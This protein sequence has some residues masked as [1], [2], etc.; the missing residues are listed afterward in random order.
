MIKM[1]TEEEMKDGMRNGMLVCAKSEEFLK[2][3]EGESVH[4]IYADPPFCTG[5]LFNGSLPID[6]IKKEFIAFEDI[7]K[8]RI[9]GYINRMKI[10]LRECHRILKPTGSMYLH[11][12]HHVLH[13]LKVAMDEIFGPKNFRNDIIWRRTNSTKSSQYD[14]KKYSVITDNILFYSKDYKNLYFSPKRT[15]LTEEEKR[16]KYNLT[17]ERGRYYLRTLLRGK[18][19]GERPNLVYEYEGFTPDIYGWRMKKEKVIKLDNEGNLVFN[20]KGKP[21]RKIRIEEEKGTDSS[22]LWLDINRIQSSRQKESIDF[23]TQKPEE[24]IRRIILASTKPR[25]IVLDP[26]CG[27][28]TTAYTATASLQRRAIAIDINPMAIVKTRGRIPGRI[29]VFGVGEE[30]FEKF[31]DERIDLKPFVDNHFESDPLVFQDWAV[32]QLGGFVPPE[33]EGIDGCIPEINTGIQVKRSYGVGTPVYDGFRG[34]LGKKRYDE[35]IIVAF[36]FSDNI[37]KQIEKDVSIEEPLKIRLITTK[38]L[39]KGKTIEDLRNEMIKVDG[40]G[41]LSKIFNVEL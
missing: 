8:Y 15:P 12:D 35:G 23:P 34:A 25:E 39:L 28:G 18:S 24:L 1:L 5:R 26:F 29:E 19:M 3:L 27:G 7:C 37:I 36:S 38:E 41:I 14:P 32:S 13:Y 16:E 30:E 4:M 11:C 40:P 22:N 6:N 20:S 17:D 2:E 21:Y 9:E 33:D 10:V 31:V